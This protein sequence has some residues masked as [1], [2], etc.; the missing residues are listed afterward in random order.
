LGKY[1]IEEQ[2]LF[3]N[4]L[5]TYKEDIH[6]GWWMARRHL[7]GPLLEEYSKQFSKESFE[8]DH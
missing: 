4:P 7:I 5:L 6:S 1:T 2:M 3:K 8:T